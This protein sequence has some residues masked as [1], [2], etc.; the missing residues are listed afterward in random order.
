MKQLYANKKKNYT[1]EEESSS[2]KF[3][4]EFPGPNLKRT[5]VMNVENCFQLSP[6]LLTECLGN[7]GV[8]LL[9]LQ[10]LWV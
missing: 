3:M 8:L 1:N 6:A 9:G 4:M 2:V 5:S 7:A 10:L